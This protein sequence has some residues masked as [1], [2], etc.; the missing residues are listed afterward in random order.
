MTEREMFEKSFQRPSN[1]FKLSSERQWEIDKELGILDWMGDD[2][3]KEDMERFHIHYDINTKT[4]KK[5]TLKD[6]FEAGKELT[7]HEWHMDEFH[8]TSCKCKPLTYQDFESWMEQI[9]S[10]TN[11]H[12]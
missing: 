3:S 10:K 11:G 5:P 6:A 7:S 1:Y 12:I 2:L 9:K 8:G 4:K